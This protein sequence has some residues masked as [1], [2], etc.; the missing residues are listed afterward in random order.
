MSDK[1]VNSYEEL[2]TIRKK[3]FCL[4]TVQANAFDPFL[5]PVSTVGSRSSGFTPFH[6]T[7]K[8]L[9]LNTARL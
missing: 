3:Y 1:A 9:P 8:V 2:K 7:V 4:Q 6:V 5:L